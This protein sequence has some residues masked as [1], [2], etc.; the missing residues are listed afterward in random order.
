MTIRL[1]ADT[2]AHRAS[3]FTATGTVASMSLYFKG[4]IIY[5]TLPE[6]LLIELPFIQLTNFT[7]AESNGI[8]TA[9][10]D[11]EAVHPAGTHWDDPLTIT[12]ISDDAGAY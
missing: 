7:Y 6:F 4:K 1:D 8:F 3:I 9:Q 10:M 2:Y 5:G 12:M 11:W